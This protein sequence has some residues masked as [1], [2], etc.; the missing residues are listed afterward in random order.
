MPQ[1]PPNTVFFF[2]KKNLKACNYFKKF[3]AFL[4]TPLTTHPKNN[5]KL[6]QINSAQFSLDKNPHSSQDNTKAR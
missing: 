6:C 1:E 4:L 2:F 5:K 3:C